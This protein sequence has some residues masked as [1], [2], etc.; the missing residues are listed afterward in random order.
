MNI[1]KIAQYREMLSKYL[2]PQRSRVLILAVLLFG[3]IGLQL[4][5]PQ[6][7]RFFIDTAVQSGT[8][9]YLTPTLPYPYQPDT[10]QDQLLLA[11]IIF[12][13]VALF[14]QGVSIVAVYFSENV[15]WTATNMLRADL[16]MHCMKLDMSFHHVR[17]PGEMIERVDTDVTQIANF[18]SQFVIMV[19]AN[20]LL[21][22]G[23]LVLLFREHAVVGLV[24]AGFALLTMWALN[25]VRSYAI[26]AWAASR[27]ASAQ[28][29]GFLEEQLSG[30]EDT[31]A[32]GAVPYT[33]RNFYRLLY[34]RLKSEQHAGMMNVTILSVIVMC[35]TVGTILSFIL[36]FALNQTGL[37]TIGTVFMFVT[38]TNML[39]RPMREITIQIQELQK[40]GAGIGRVYELLNIETKIPEGPGKPIPSGALTVDFDDVTFS[41]NNDETVLKNF[42]FHLQPGRVIG[43]LGRT[44]SGKTTISR[45]LFRLYDVKHGTIRL[46]GTDIRDATI[47]DLRQRVGIVTQDVQLFRASVRV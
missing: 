47:R 13:L 29:Y 36:G 4:V 17:T 38:Y 33:L 11:A 15:G 20:I 34:D 39:F 27:E 5:S 3:S 2:K 31:R 35:V 14:Q 10:T 44:G 12:I 8:Q 28:F 7:L 18:F 1:P 45:L 22:V 19:L 23:V 6:I 21:L 26:P 24:M 30:T 32:S 42:D 40:A 16:A 43:L 41:Y 46:G 37:V 9:P 25:K